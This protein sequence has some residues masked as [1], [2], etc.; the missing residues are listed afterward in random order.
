MFERRP[1]DEGVMGALDTYSKSI[2]RTAANR[3][4]EQLALADFFSRRNVV[5]HTPTEHVSPL[6]T[7]SH[8]APKNVDTTFAYVLFMSVLCGNDNIVKLTSLKDTNLRQRMIIEEFQQFLPLQL[9]DTITL[10]ESDPSRETNDQIAAN[11]DLRIIWGGDKT[12]GEIRQ[13]MLRAHA[14]DL[15]FH[16]RRSLALID[17]SNYLKDETLQRGLQSDVTWMSQQ[18]CTSVKAIIWTGD[19]FEAATKVFSDALPKVGENVFER[20]VWLQG[21]IIRGGIVLTD[22]R[23]PTSNAVCRIETLLNE[24]ELCTAAGT[25]LHVKSSSPADLDVLK[26]NR[27]IQTIV[28]DAWFI[29][30]LTQFA[31]RSRV[32]DRIVKPGKSMMFDWSWDGHNLVNELTHVIGTPK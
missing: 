9:R 23:H 10:V 11:S 21:L 15:A 29:N 25:V 22:H 32:C 3:S 24:I 16:D 30:G 5:N 17:S 2:M 20:F 13:S 14:R 26:N 28:T 27:K 18:S 1:F 8:Y 12:I 4:P 19:D 31:T 6:G 7:V